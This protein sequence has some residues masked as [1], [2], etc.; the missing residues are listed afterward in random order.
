MSQDKSSWN[1]N[2]SIEDR[3]LLMEHEV[4]VHKRL[5]VQFLLLELVKFPDGNEVKCVKKW[6]TKDYR[7]RRV[8][9]NYFTFI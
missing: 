7:M 1:E 5:S 9:T 2:K 4:W 6:W 8:T 3:N